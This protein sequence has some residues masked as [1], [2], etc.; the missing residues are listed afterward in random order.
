LRIVKMGSLFA[1]DLHAN[2]CGKSTG[3]NRATF[4]H[5]MGAFGRR[6]DRLA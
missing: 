2:A 3:Q 5:K 4:C 1:S 6:G